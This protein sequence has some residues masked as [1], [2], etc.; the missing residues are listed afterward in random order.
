MYFDYFDLLSGSEVLLRGVG[1]LRSPLVGELKPNSGLGYQAYRL[2]LGVLSWD[3]EHVLKYMRLMEYRGVDKLTRNELTV[4]D[5]FVLIPQMRELCRGVLSFFMVENLVWDA[6]SRIFLVMSPGEE[7]VTVGEITRDN[8]ED[9]RAAMLQMNYVGL[10][11][12]DTPI[13]HSS[14]KSKELWE[15]AQQ[16]LKEQANQD[17]EDS[18]PEYKLSNIVSKVCSIHPSYNLLNICDLTIFQLYDTFFQLSYMR[19]ADLSERIFSNHG[20]EKFKFE[21]WLKPIQTNI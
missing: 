20:G 1:H 19:S 14:E 12:D 7:S 15:K 6:R 21:A 13:K 8:F 11:K 17:T 4:F 10:D 9:V 5:V 3:K 18:K 16:Y 2:Y